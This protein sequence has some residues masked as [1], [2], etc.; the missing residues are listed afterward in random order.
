MPAIPASITA[1]NIIKLTLRP[2]CGLGLAPG[3]GVAVGPG[4]APTG[5]HIAVMVIL[6]VMV[7]ELPVR[8]V[9]SGNRQPP[10]VKPVRLGFA[11]ILVITVPRGPTRI[12][13]SLLTE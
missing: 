13:V 5:V 9:P 12:P 7:M 11:G 4:V 8:T 2:V 10:N 3:P 1:P 6:P